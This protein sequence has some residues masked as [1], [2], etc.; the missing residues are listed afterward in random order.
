M[1]DGDNFLFNVGDEFVAQLTTPLCVLEGND[2][3]H[4][5]ETSLRIREL[6]ADVLYIDSWK[7]EAVR[8]DAMRQVREFLAQH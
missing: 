1:Y 3:Y 2:L 7:E 5:Q 4:P 6:A 8:A